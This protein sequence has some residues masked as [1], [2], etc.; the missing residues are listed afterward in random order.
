[1]AHT[2][3]RSRKQ[4]HEKVNQGPRSFEETEKGKQFQ[5]NREGTKEE[6][7]KKKEEAKK[8]KDKDNKKAAAGSTGSSDNHTS[9]SSPSLRFVVDN[10]NTIIQLSKKKIK[11]LQTQCW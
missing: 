10:I 8:E 5:K 1:V 2:F 4:K 7:R 9:S 6:E 11:L 3:F